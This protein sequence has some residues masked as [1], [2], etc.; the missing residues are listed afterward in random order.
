[1]ILEH[2][3]D[4]NRCT[5]C[6]A[7]LASCPKGAIIIKKHDEGFLY[8]SI[9]QEKCVSCNIC[10]HICPVN[11]KLDPID[12]DTECYAAMAPDEVRLSSSSGGI[13]TIAARYFIKNGGYVCQ[14][15][16]VKA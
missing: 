2:P 4:I 3:T 6:M 16:L 9:V 7:C 5:G 10:V 14:C 15:H 12:K 8:P 13:F 11:K 1:M